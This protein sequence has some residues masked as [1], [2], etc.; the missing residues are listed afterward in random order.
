VEILL[1]RCGN[2]MDSEEKVLL[3]TCIGEVGAISV[4]LLEERASPLNSA[5]PLQQP[6]WHS[7]ADRYELLLVT[8]HLV[9]A[10][11]AATISNDQHKIA[12]TIQQILALL[13]RSASEGGSSAREKSSNIDGKRGMSS[14]LSAKLREAG[15]LD[16]VEPFW[17]SEF[18][19]VRTVCCPGLC[20]VLLFLFLPHS[21]SG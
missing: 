6:P 16:T 17:W 9:T 10:L 8:N 1:N 5:E 7:R 11:K 4:H 21:L 3:A 2:G 15:V 18:R 20:F 14:W 12:F 19:E 13:D